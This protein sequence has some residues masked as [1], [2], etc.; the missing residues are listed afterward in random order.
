MYAQM[1]QN[2]THFVEGLNMIVKVSADI[3][4]LHP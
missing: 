3:T 4:F 1:P 2:I